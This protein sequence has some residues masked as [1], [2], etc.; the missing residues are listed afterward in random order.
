MGSGESDNLENW[1]QKECDIDNN[2]KG[3]GG[4][5][6]E[7]GNKNDE[8]RNDNNDNDCKDENRDVVEG[9]FF[10]PSKEMQKKRQ[11]INRS[12]SPDRS[13]LSYDAEITENSL[14][15]TWL[16]NTWKCLA[17]RHWDEWSTESIQGVE[18]CTSTFANNDHCDYCAKW[19]S[20]N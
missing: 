17:S 6:D 3:N 19:W 11:L 10:I 7:D 12:T 9:K 1:Y 4:G 5:N 8:D 18:A 16:Q 20:I 13:I 2:N 15:Y 14:A